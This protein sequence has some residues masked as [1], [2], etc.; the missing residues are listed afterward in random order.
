M[1]KDS[2]GIVNVFASS[3]IQELKTGAWKK[4]LNELVSGEFMIEVYWDN[5]LY[6]PTKAE[7]Y[8]RIF[9]TEQE[10]SAF[11]GNLEGSAWRKAFKAIDSEV[12]ENGKQS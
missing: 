2:L 8:E 12:K 6:E 3:Y 7:T 9:P 11:Y 10:A 1:N 5:W 4:Q